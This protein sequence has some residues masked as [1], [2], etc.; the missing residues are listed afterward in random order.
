MTRWCSI[1]FHPFWLLA[2]VVPVSLWQQ[3]TAYP[4]SSFAMYAKN[5]RESQLVYLA[6]SDGQPIS[7]VRYTNLSSAK[8]TKLYNTLLR[9]ECRRRRIRISTAPLEV[10]RA[11]ASRLLD[12]AEALGREHDCPALPRGAHI[13]HV[14]LE[15]DGQA[16]IQTPVA[17]AER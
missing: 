16:L 7:L 6:D 4:F 15:F 12:A 17:L 11:A 1:L 8:A 5:D 9:D 2:M 14:T 3:D 10:H 13:V